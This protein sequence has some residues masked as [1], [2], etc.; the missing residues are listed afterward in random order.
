MK[1]AA[2]LRAL[3]ATVVATLIVGAGAATATAEEAATVTLGA[4]ETLTLPAGDG[5]RD[6]AS[7]SITADA[8]TTVALE[9]RHVEGE[10]VATL[11]SVDITDPGTPASA[12]I[13]VA[14]LPAGALEVVATPVGGESVVAAL[15]VGSGEPSS[16]SLSLSAS[17]IFTWS[18]AS[19]RSTTATVTAVDET[20]LAVP[21]TGSVTAKVG[22]KTSTAAVTSTTGTAATAS[23]PVSKFTVGTGTVV[24][25]VR[26]LAGSTYYQSG[27][28]S[29]KVLQTA[30]MSV[31]L[32]RSLSTVYP[33][34]DSYRDTVK[35]TITPKSSTGVVVPAT[36]SVKV[37][38]SG[39]TIKSWS[40]T[41]SKTQSFTWDG[42]VSGRIV[43]GTY[44]VTVTIKGPEGYTKTAS[45][46]V[47]VSSKKLVTVTTTRTYL[48]KSV[49]TAYDTF[50]YYDQSECWS[51][52]SNGNVVCSGYDAPDGLSMWAYGSVPIPADV[53]AAQQYG[54]VKGS[55]TMN[56]VDG[57]GT[58]SWGYDK[59]AFGSAKIGPVQIGSNSLGTL[60]LSAPAKRVYVTVA[61]GEYTDLEV[62]KF[63]MRYQYKVL[64]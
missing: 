40:L 56:L 29:L 62:G 14:D 30:V 33:S 60:Y 13:S 31:S 18:K 15:T 43:P 63:T 50:D 9:I 47:V 10:P 41:S 12:S 20:G 1:H 24:A 57:Y 55:V 45:T 23:F 36:G 11:P 26:S 61:L 34:K 22:T 7:L 54:G 59:S 25:K 49:L 4:L 48:A 27:T 53:I 46:K 37:T 16:V 5:V 3:S 38:K 42:K 44:S 52:S 32:S 64:K 28:K 8:A 39:K 17:T 58:A 51:V 19:P 6:S 35:F 2:H 21:F